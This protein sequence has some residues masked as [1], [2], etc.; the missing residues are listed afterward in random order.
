MLSIG[1]SDE[2]IDKI[3]NELEAGTIPLGNDWVPWQDAT[4]G[5]FNLKRQAVIF[6]ATL[7]QAETHYYELD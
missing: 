5:L 7:K 2:E 6:E 4:N 1:L 3:I